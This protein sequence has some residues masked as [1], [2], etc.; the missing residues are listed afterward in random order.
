MA[1]GTENPIRT[2]KNALKMATWDPP[3]LWYA[4]AVAEMKNR[5]LTEPTSWRYQAAIHGFTLDPDFSASVFWQQWTQNQNLPAKAEQDSFWEKCQHGTWY[6]LPWHRMYLGYFEQ[7]VRKIVISLGGPSDWALPYWNYNQGDASGKLPDAF[8]N[9]KLPD[10]SPNALFEP[11]RDFGN[12]GKPFLPA[13]DVSLK[14]A[15]KEHQFAAGAH[16]GTQ[17][18]GGPITGDNH[19]AHSDT[20]SGILEMQPHN[21]VHGDVGGL[22]GDPDTAAYDP[23]FWLH[24]ANIDRLW[25][26]WLKADAS[27]KN[28]TDP[29]WLTSVA[30]NFHDGLGNF[31]KLKPNDVL[32]TKANPFY[33]EYDDVSGPVSSAIAPPPGGV[34]IPHSL[35]PMS[36]ES[37]P[38]MVGASSEATPLANESKTLGIR[39]FPMS[40]PH[41]AT[42]GTAETR[43]QEAHLNVENVRG[44]G[45]PAN[46]D[47]YLNVPEGGGEPPEKYHV[48]VLPMF[49]LERASIATER[50]PGNGL[51]FTFNVTEI[52]N[53]LK[54]QK[55]WN[56]DL[57]RVTFAP[58]Q[59][60]PEGSN[61]EIGRVSLYFT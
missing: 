59:K 40:G 42:L 13:R 38:E 32:N 47:V 55:Q 29:K 50:H 52:I 46:Y 57:L 37:I 60:L 34:A 12:N 31:P 44:K 18:F 25:E 19:S 27:N 45:Q 30:F 36:E 3:L 58:R 17:G 24:H 5:P 4:K 41:L 14:P 53:L 7:I 16:G 10:A 56:S 11:V 8:I 39:L 51:R 48:G 28:P 22:M 6:F 20:P 54:A 21:N 15:F 35:K 1:N 2:R 49:G 9:L 33:Y 26:V 23:I 43:F 61:L